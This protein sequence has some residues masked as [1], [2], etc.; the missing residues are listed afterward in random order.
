MGHRGWVPNS[1]HCLSLCMCLH[2]R[3]ELSVPASESPLGVS[4]VPAHPRT[5]VQCEALQKSSPSWTSCRK[6]RHN[7]LWRP[8]QT[9]RGCFNI[10]NCLDTEFS[11]ELI[12]GTC[13]LRNKHCPIEELCWLPTHCPVWD[14]ALGKPYFLIIYLHQGFARLSG[15]SFYASVEPFPRW[16]T[17]QSTAV[18]LDCLYLLLS[19]E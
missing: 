12:L 7:T 16:I 6:M 13:F 17:M 3:A 18:M 19:G 8:E 9:R 1:Q 11:Q 14:G 5:Q 10:A 2:S 15:K 4:C